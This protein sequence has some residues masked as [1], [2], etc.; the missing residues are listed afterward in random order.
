MVPDSGAGL[1]L[2]R[3]CVV[4]LNCSAPPAKIR[5]SLIPQSSAS[6]GLSAMLTSSD[7][8]SAQSAALRR[9]G[10]VVPPP[11]CG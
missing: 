3:V 6:Q 2:G 5:G 10:Q 8:R 9:T 11:G 4:S 7:W 1:R